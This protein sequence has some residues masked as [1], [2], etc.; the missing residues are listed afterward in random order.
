MLEAPLFLLTGSVICILIFAIKY[1]GGF[2]LKA[3]IY[4]TFCIYL[5]TLIIC[6]TFPLPVQKS[7]IAFL[8]SYKPVFVPFTDLRNW[9]ADLSF[10][11][12]IGMVTKRV[13]LLFPMGF[14]LPLLMPRA[15]SFRS[16]LQFGIMIA[17]VPELLKYLIGLILGT[18]YKSVSI[19]YVILYFVG[20]LFGSLVFFVLRPWLN[21]S[22]RLSDYSF[23]IR[24]N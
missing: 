15:K 9:L 22:I 5:L 16:S 19:D 4:M 18:F 17:L 3:F 12:A 8:P 14:F 20:Y 23:T 21:K 10:V 11:T 24:G 2:N 6:L 7:L 1:R 13:L